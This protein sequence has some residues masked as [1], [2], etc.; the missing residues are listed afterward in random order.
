MELTTENIQDL[1]RE[2]LNIIAAVKEIE[3]CGDNLI[4]DADDVAKMFG[5]GTAV[6]REFM[7]RPDFP[8]IKIGKKLQ[9]NRLALVK[10]TMNRIT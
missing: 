5:W 8:L 7:N 6:T 10:Y 1:N 4:M 9:V 3:T 2:L